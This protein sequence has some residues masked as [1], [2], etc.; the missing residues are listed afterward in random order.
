[1]E[2]I[3][4]IHNKYQNIGGEDLA[5]KNEVELL[6]KHFIVDT[7]YF[8]NEI[9]NTFLQGIWFILNQNLQSKKILRDK[10]QEFD[11]D[12][13]YV[14]NTW[15]KASL[16][17]FGV[18]KEKKIPTFIKLHNFRY[19]CTKSFHIKNHLIN[20]KTC[21]A[22]GL[23]KK[24][25]KKFNKYFESSNLKSLLVL[26]YGKRYFKLLKNSNFKLLVLTNF[27]KEFLINLGFA[28]NKIFKFSNYI[29]F[30]YETKNN[31]K[32]DYIVYA[33]RVSKEKGVENLIDSFL[34]SEVSFMTLKIVGEGPEL[35]NLQNKYKSTNIKFTGLQSNSDTLEIIKSAKAVVTATKLYEGQPNLLCEASILGVPSIFPSS[36]G[37]K[38]FF[39]KNYQLCFKQFDY[40]DLVQK[41]NFINNSFEMEKISKENRSYI[42]NFLSKKKIIND[43]RKALDG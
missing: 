38:E 26:R 19:F 15:F 11:P 31:R 8:S 3:L 16:G 35:T 25:L 41:L 17:I 43:F 37:I 9:N 34:I 10:I 32:E 23:E 30:Q 40:E 21:E 39:P 12:I 2:K 27:H 13:A 4:I 1:V 5:V 28:R 42:I 24:S 36:G 7:L 33:G 20:N 29:S 6:R 22:C 18:L 14:H